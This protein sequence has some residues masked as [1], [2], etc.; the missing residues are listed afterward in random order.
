MNVYLVPQN[1]VSSSTKNA[2]W[3]H[4]IAG[5]FLA[6]QAW[7][8]EAQGNV[9]EGDALVVV[10]NGTRHGQNALPVIIVRQGAEVVAVR[11]Q[12]VAQALA[13]LGHPITIVDAPSA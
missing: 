5:D 7:A 12:G 9:P 10:V 3:N 2:R 6:T 4:P 8:W 13:S 1:T 11:A